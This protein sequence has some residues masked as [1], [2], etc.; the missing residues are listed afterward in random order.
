MGAFFLLITNSNPGFGKKV[1]E[2]TITFKILPQK[3]SKPLSLL[4]F[5][6]TQYIRY[7]ADYILISSALNL[8]NLEILNITYIVKKIL[9]D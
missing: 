2:G 3:R 1:A 6:K 9:Q 5:F 4:A 7:Y 8:I